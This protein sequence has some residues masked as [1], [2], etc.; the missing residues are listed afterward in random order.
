[1]AAQTDEKSLARLHNSAASPDE[2]TAR[3]VAKDRNHGYAC[4]R[5]WALETAQLFEVENVVTYGPGYLMRPRY[6][7]FQNEEIYRMIRNEPRG[8]DKNGNPKNTSVNC[9]PLVTEIFGRGDNCVL[10]VTPPMAHA[11]VRAVIDVYNR[12]LDLYG[13]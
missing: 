11:F 1:M 4:G 13:Q 8:L 9:S 12:Y 6:A 3:Q 5:K 7:L 2:N 10:S